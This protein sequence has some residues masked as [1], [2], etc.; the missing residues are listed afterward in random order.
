MDKATWKVKKVFVS[1]DPVK[2]ED[3]KKDFLSSYI[4]QVKKD[5]KVEF[6]VRGRNVNDDIENPL[7]VK[8]KKEIGE[9]IGWVHVTGEKNP[10]WVGG[11]AEMV[12]RN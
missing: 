1:D 6:W 2:F 3:V 5:G 8:S 4:G 12:H 11:K 7:K 10:R 9:F